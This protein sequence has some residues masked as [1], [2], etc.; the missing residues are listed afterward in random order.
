[1]DKKK[2]EQ[3]VE[4]KVETMAATWVEERET[5][6]GGMKVAWMADE[7]VGLWVDLR[8]S[9]WVVVMAA[10]TAEWWELKA[11]VMKVETMVAGL[12][13]KT[14]GMKVVWKVV[15]M[16][17]LL[18]LLSVNSKEKKMAALTVEKWGLQK[19]AVMVEKRE[20]AKEM[21]LL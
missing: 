16:V 13:Y 18:V 21:T 6:M 7:M 5:W 2:A 15:V 9:Y 14:V 3:L 20:P 11:V 17:V 19:D 1:M 4:L 10:L 8:D 12:A